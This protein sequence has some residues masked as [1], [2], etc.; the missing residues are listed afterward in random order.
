MNPSIIRTGIRFLAI[1]LAAIVASA[2]LSATSS[3]AALPQRGGDMQAPTPPAPKLDPKE[4][5]A[6][7]AFYTAS[8]QDATARIQLGQDFIQKYPIECKD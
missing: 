3:A 7:K 8:P 4:E 2:T 1:T 6:Y 5:A